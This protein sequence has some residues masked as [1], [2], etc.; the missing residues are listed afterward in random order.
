MSKGERRNRRPTPRAQ[1]Q[2]AATCTETGWMP[3]LTVNQLTKEFLRY[4]NRRICNSLQV[5]QQYRTRNRSHL[6]YQE[7]TVSKMGLKN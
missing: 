1:K 2:E 3:V 5:L 7:Q 4:G 6:D